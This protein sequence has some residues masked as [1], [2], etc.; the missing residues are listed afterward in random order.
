MDPWDV[1]IIGAIVVYFFTIRGF[2]LIGQ[3]RDPPFPIWPKIGGWLIG[4]SWPD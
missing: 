1:L 4:K 3:P 2:D